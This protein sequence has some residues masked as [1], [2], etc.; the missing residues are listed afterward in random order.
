MGI[1]FKFYLFW[2]AYNKF[3]TYFYIPFDIKDNQ[4]I[5]FIINRCCNKIILKKITKSYDK[6]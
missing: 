5:I 2:M 4:N 3:L 1:I 6:L